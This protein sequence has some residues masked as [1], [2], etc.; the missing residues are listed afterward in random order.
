M[1]ELSRLVLLQVVKQLKDKISINS[2]EMRINGYSEIVIEKKFK[3]LWEEKCFLG[4]DFTSH[5]ER[6]RYF[7][8]LDLSIKGEEYL[9]KLQKEYE[10]TTFRG[11]WCA[12]WHKVI[13]I[14]IS[15]GALIISIISL[16]AKFPVKT[17]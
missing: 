9:A 2:K 11:W 16:V 17:P 3:Q 13:P 14:V 1:R 6:L 7:E 8:I 10:E 12:N 4:N 15:I 5:N